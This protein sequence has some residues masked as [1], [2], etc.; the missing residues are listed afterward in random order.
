ML[1]IL[2]PFGFVDN[3]DGEY[4][5]IIFHPEIRWTF[6]TEDTDINK[7]IP[8]L[9]ADLQRRG[10]NVLRAELQGLLKQQ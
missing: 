1:A 8:M 6:D 3:L 9:A 5:G 2:S 7:L 4:P 10:A